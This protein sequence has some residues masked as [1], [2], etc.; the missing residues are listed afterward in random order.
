MFINLTQW[1]EKIKKDYNITLPKISATYFS[2][3][4]FTY[5]LIYSL[6]CI[7]TYTHIHMH[8]YK[9]RL[10][11]LTYIH[12]YIPI[13][14]HLYLY[15]CVHIQTEIYTHIHHL[16][17]H[18]ILTRSFSAPVLPAQNSW[19]GC[20]QINHKTQLSAPFTPMGKYHHR[21]QTT[22]K[23]NLPSSS[24]STCQ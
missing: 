5:T 8:T 16:Y 12:T 19:K 24:H 14:T 1:K 15:I 22:A 17:A 21:L 6:T 13:Y 20:G 23:Q 3:S 11:M 10:L 18:I 2:L 7:H 9:H 4:Y